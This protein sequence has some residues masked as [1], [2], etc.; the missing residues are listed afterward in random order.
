M[1]K[2]DPRPVRDDFTSAECAKIL[3]GTIG[4]LVDMASYEAVSEAIAFWSSATGQAK[5]RELYGREADSEPPPA[6]EE[7]RR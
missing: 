4:A 3:G 5:L 6:S 2:L 1:V 7:A